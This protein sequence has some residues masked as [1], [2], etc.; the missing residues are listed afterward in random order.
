M[1]LVQFFCSFL[2][3]ISTKFNTFWQTL[4][5]IGRFNV[6]QNLNTQTEHYTYNMALSGMHM[7]AKQIT[8]SL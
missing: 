3:N 1:A 7:Y 2:L 8:I 5:R 6:I 4:A